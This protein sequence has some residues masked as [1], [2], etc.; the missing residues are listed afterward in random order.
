MASFRQYANLLT[1]PLL[2]ALLMCSASHVFAQQPTRDAQV[3][4]PDEEQAARMHREMEKKANQRRHAELKHDTDQLLELATELK[5]YVDH[6][7]E[8]M[9]SLDVVR[10]A[11]Q[12]EKLAHNVREKMKGD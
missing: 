12:I 5:Q 10:K 8:N 3:P 4:Q 7:N 2:L 1:L 11:E 9:L 6:S